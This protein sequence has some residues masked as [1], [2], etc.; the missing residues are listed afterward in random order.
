M[1]IY[2][3]G[4]TVAREFGVS[5]EISDNAS[6]A[7]DNYVPDDIPSVPE[8]NFNQGIEEWARWLDAGGL[9]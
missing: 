2:Q 1:T 4:E 7:I 8:K 3:A 6:P 5:I 9:N